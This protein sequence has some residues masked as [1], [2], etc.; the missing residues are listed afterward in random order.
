MRNWDTDGI[1]V[2]HPEFFLHWLCTLC[3]KTL[4]EGSFARVAHGKM[5]VRR[6][7]AVVREEYLSD[8]P[9]KVFEKNGV[10][11]RTGEGRPAHE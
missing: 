2:K 3:G 10:S 11:E 5:H 9:R 1:F 8:G 4:K 7:E 6:G